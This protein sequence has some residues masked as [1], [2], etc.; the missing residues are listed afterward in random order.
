MD[1]GAG[2][3]DGAVDAHQMMARGREIDLGAVEHDIADAQDQILALVESG[4]LQVDGQILDG[5]IIGA[6]TRQWPG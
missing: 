3:R 5:A 1:H 6:R 4:R 2:F